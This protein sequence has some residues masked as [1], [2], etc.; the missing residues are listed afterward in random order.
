MELYQ[1]P[2]WGLLHSDSEEEDDGVPN[3][4]KNVRVEGWKWSKEPTVMRINS[5]SD[6]INQK[7]NDD[8]A[9]I[10]KRVEQQ[11]LINNI[12]IG[13]DDELVKLLVDRTIPRDAMSVLAADVNETFTRATTPPDFV[14]AKSETRDTS[15]DDPTNSSDENQKEK[16]TILGDKDE[17]QKL[18]ITEP[19][20]EANSSGKPESTS[21]STEPTRISKLTTKTTDLKNQLAALMKGKTV[22]HVDQ[23]YGSGKHAQHLREHVSPGTTEALQKGT[24]QSN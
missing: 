3:T 24:D 12:D 22:K 20:E 21:E 2:E 18:P 10:C 1:E 19:E 23:M 7:A 6:Y 11:A 14:D 5:V 8:I 13:G 16:S 17:S 15:Q 4:R 9:T